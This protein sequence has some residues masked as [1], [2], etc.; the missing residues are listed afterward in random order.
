MAANPDR[1][2][3]ARP[4]VGHCLRSEPNGLLSPDQEVT[5]IPIGDPVLVTPRRLGAEAAR[6]WAAI[7]RFPLHG[8]RPF[9]S[10]TVIV[11]PPKGIDICL[12]I[13]IGSYV[14]IGHT[15]SKGGVRWQASPKR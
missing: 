8:F 7:V 13:G 10:Q 3:P 6:L 15:F 11:G 9:N 4:P 2:P 14:T 12:P 1:R 5:I